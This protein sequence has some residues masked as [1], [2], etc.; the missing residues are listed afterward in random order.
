MIN[1]VE[2]QLNQF[3]CSKISKPESL[4]LNSPMLQRKEGYNEVLRT[5][6]RF[7]LAVKLIWEGGEDVYGA[8]KK[9][10]PFYMSIGFS[11]S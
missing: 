8:G 5:W 1:K 11:S 9:I 7:E 6:F 3:N 10:L 4:K 2:S